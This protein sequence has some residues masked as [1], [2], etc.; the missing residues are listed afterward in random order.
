MGWGSKKAGSS[1]NRKSARRNRK[2]SA[3]ATGPAMPT[4]LVAASIRRKIEKIRKAEQQAFGPRHKRT[5]FY[6]Y[7][8]T[9]YV[10]W[11]WTD[12]AE[13]KRVGRAV[14]AL[15]GI[16]SRQN[17]SPLRSVIDATTKISDRHVKSRWAQALEYAVA[18]KVP[19]R[20]F[21]TFLQNNGGVI[22]CEGKMADLRKRK[23]A[24]QKA[25][26]A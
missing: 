16:V 7:L 19:G 26:P 5:A 6:D 3:K 4:G 15:Y 13:S 1:R 12:P 11:D 21:K 14:A 2:S 18:K 17:K 24:S 10:A 8:K 22:G 20:R 9:I 23:A 25:R